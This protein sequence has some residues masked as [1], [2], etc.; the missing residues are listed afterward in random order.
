MEKNPLIHGP[1][2]LFLLNAILRP[3]NYRVISIL[4]FF[5]SPRSE[6]TKPNLF[7]CGFDRITLGWSI[8]PRDP[9]GAAAAAAAAAADDDKLSLSLKGA[10]DFS[11]L[12]EHQAPSSASASAASA[13][14]FAGV[15]SVGIGAIGGLRG[16]VGAS[17][18][19]GR[20][21]GGK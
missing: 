4:R 8:Q 1:I 19:G 17:M 20:D 15:G 5:F 14:P 13:S 11:S 7:T 18:A 3:I 12:R 21:A 2:Q 6:D 16:D 9:G 10:K